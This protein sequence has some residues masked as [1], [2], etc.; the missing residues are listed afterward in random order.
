MAMITGRM[1]I[2]ENPKPRS[3]NVGNSF[4][5]REG[6]HYTC[7]ISSVEIK[8]RILLKKEKLN[9]EVINEK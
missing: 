6:N 5:I 2:K 9:P 8:K 3:I 1:Q 4:T 7:K